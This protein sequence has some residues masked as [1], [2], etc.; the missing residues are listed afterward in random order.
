M[1]YEFKLGHNVA[2]AIKT[3]YYVE[4]AVMLKVVQ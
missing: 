4:S 3:I 1:L 2:E